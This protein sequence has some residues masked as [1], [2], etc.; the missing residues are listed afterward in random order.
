VKLA[1]R[2]GVSRKTAERY[3]YDRALPPPARRVGMLVGLSGAVDDTLVRRLGAALEVPAH[4]WPVPPAA[5][6]IPSLEDPIDLALFASAERHGVSPAHA[7]LIAL[8]MLTCVVQ[9]NA[10]V[11][12]AHAALVTVTTKRAVARMAK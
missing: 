8:D 10:N 4:Q 9:L 5:P 2:L 3:V 7:R 6:V 11:L 1:S 12:L